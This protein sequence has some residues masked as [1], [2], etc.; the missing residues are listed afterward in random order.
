MLVLYRFCKAGFKPSAP[1]LAIA[2]A[3]QAMILLELPAEGLLKCRIGNDV[4]SDVTE[5]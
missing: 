1:V 5:L 2:P 3:H 4:I